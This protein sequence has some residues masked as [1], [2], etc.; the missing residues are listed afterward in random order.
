M[1]R[2]SKCFLTALRE[3][4]PGAA[5]MVAHHMRKQGG[6]EEDRSK[7]AENMRDWSDGARGSGAIV[8]PLYTAEMGSRV[9]S[10]PPKR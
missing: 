8:D 7:L 5:V 6:R 2:R 1:T 3:N 10:A 9:E 4:F